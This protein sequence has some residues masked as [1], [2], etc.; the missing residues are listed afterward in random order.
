M[1]GTLGLNNSSNFLSNGLNK[2]LKSSNQYLAME[3]EPMI[4]NQVYSTLVDY[5]YLSI[6]MTTI[7]NDL[8]LLR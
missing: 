4:L 2:T 6:K 5:H 8:M 7:K 1:M 3:F